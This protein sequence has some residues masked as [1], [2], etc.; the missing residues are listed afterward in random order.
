M[1]YAPP[2]PTSIIALVVRKQVSLDYVNHVQIVTLVRNVLIV[3]IVLATM[4][5]K[6]NAF[7]KNGFQARPCA[8][9]A[10]IWEVLAWEALTLQKCLR[11]TKIIQ[12]FSAVRRVTAVPGLHLMTFLLLP[13]SMHW[14]MRQR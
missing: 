12:H 6:V 11:L 14:M 7:P 10:R 9:R 4:M 8:V 5:Q 2:V 1:S 13:T 3:L